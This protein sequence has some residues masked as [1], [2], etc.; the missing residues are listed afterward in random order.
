VV[1]LLLRTPRAG[2]LEALLEQGDV[3]VHTPA[4]CD[5]EVASAL[6]RL[7]VAGALPDTRRDEALADYR[8]LPLT[9]HGHLAL[10]ERV[11]ELGGNFS[12]YDATYVALAEV[13]GAD[14]VTA[15]ERLGRAVRAHTKLR[16]A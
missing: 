13:L 16:L 3:D 1:E 4:L 2:H 15:D 8:D 6:R 14:L 9:R 10:L 12:S 5:V 11:L 7:S